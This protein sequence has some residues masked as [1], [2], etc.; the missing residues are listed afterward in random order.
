VLDFDA[1]ASAGLTPSVKRTLLAAMGE[2]GG[3]PS[4]NSPQGQ[5]LRSKIGESR[6][7]LAKLVGCLPEQVVFTS[8]ATEAN[9]MVI[10]GLA[11]SQKSRIVT[12][13]TEHASVLAV[14]EELE[15]H[16][17]DVVRLSVDGNGVISLDELK[18]ALQTETDL[19]SV[20]WVNSETGVFQPIGEVASICRNSNVPLHVDAAQ[21]VGRLPIDFSN[22]DIS[23]LTFSGHKFH[24]PAGVGGVV[25]QPIDSLRPLILGGGQE[26]GL[27]SGTENWLGIVGV[28]KAAE[29]RLL[30]FEAHV[31]HLG[32]LQRAFEGALLEALPWAS[33]NSSGASRVCNTSNVFFPGV[34]GMALTIRLG[35]K[36]LQC[37]QAS[38][39]NSRKPEPSRV[40]RAMGMS[41]DEAYACVRFSFSVLNTMEEIQ[42]GVEVVVRLASALRMPRRINAA[43]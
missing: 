12:T 39:C 32:S 7:W 33:V 5:G 22:S 19:V 27:R 42:K 2:L 10:R 38:A 37:S 26:N 11:R 18:A 13:A 17:H 6:D 21:A 43:F 1:N 34:D 41:E 31:S 24:A 40:L 30:N 9:N 35:Q 28:G 8:G 23:F 4:S 16:G 14:V 20:H 29:E 36:G 3:N 25:A 15:T